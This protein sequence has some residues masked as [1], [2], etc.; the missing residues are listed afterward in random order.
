MKV[1]VVGKEYERENRG[2]IFLFF[3]E[4]VPRHLLDV[5]SYLNFRELTLLIFSCPPS[6]L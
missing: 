4:L 5:T 1:L 2:R 6:K 3:E